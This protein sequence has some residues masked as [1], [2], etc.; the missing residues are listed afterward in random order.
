MEKKNS[1]RI[2]SHHL[3]SLYYWFYLAASCFQ[4]QPITW[5][6]SLLYNKWLR[7]PNCVCFV[8][9]SGFKKGDE[10]VGVF[11]GVKLKIRFKIQLFREVLLHPLTKSNDIGPG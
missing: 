10:V 5:H 7:F 3:H 4:S 6:V 9:S 1:H 8:P 2:H 11:E